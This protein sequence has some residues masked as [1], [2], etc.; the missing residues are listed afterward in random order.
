MR[1]YQYYR[2]QNEPLS[3][4]SLHSDH[5]EKELLMERIRDLND[6]N[7]HLVQKIN[8]LKEMLQVQADGGE[9]KQKEIKNMRKKKI[10]L[11]FSIKKA[12][13]RLI[14]NVQLRD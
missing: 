8:Q 12:L 13:E 1:A 3:I 2:R 4:K 10:A 11:E 6:E 5:Q 14:T 9:K 7:L